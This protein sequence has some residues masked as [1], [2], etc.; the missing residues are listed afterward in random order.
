[1]KNKIMNKYTIMCIVFVVALITLA[2]S[3]SFAYIKL[4]TAGETTETKIKTGTFEIETSLE[5]VNSL[6]ATNMMLIN[7]D[8]IEEKA[9]SLTF[10]AKADSSNTSTGEFAIYVKDVTISKGLIDKNFKWQ[11]LQ[12]GKI[13]GNGSFENIDSDG[14][15][16]SSKTN[17]DDINYYDTYYL[18]KDIPFNGTEESSLELRIYLLNDSAVNQSN[19]MNGTFECRVGIEGYNSGN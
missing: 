13:V 9:N 3:I 6:N 18:I 2:F 11:L 1:M 10:T 4:E 16:S 7:E 15:A 5:T 14:V 12:D 17:T 8:E 19:L